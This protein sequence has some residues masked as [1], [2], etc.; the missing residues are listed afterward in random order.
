M[1]FL[2]VWHYKSTSI[3]T[4][5]CFSDENKERNAMRT[6]DDCIL[7]FKR[8]IP[9]K[10]RICTAL[11]RGA[12]SKTYS[13]DIISV[14][15]PPPWSLCFSLSLS[16]SLSHCLSHHDIPVFVLY[17]LSLSFEASFTSVRSR[18]FYTQPFLKGDKLLCLLLC[19]PSPLFWAPL[20][21]HYHLSVFYFHDTLSP[22]RMPRLMWHRPCAAMF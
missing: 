1:E 22:V 21:F 15:L 6:N 8:T 14:C 13:A 5:L 4:V 16:F 2:G 9:L 3:F 11:L 12:I 18:G 10:L 17:C 20:L 7:I 19:S